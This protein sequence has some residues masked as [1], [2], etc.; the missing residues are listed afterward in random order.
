MRGFITLVVIPVLRMP[1]DWANDLVTSGL[2]I[3]WEVVG[4]VP[5]LTWFIL[6]QIKK[7]LP[8]LMIELANDPK[9]QVAM[10]QLGA[11]V[12]Q[13][14]MPKMTI[15]NAIGMALPFLLQRF[16]GGPPQPPPPP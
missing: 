15:N 16:F 6:T 10:R 12:G 9:F 4:L 13:A 2:V 8:D 11:K 1:I 14:A 7:R 5:L 3:L